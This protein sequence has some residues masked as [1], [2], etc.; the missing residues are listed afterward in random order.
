MFVAE[1]R[2]SLAHHGLKPGLPSSGRSATQKVLAKAGSARNHLFQ[3][4]RMFEW[5]SPSRHQGKNQDI[6]DWPVWFRTPN[7]SHS[8]KCNVMIEAKLEILLVEDE[9]DDVAL[10]L[11]EFKR[12]SFCNKVHVVRSGEEALDFIYAQGNYAHRK[13]EDSLKLV[14][15]DLKLP[16]MHGLDVLRRI[17]SDDHSK[18]LSVV[19]LTASQEER[20]VMQCYK[21]GA[22][23]CIVKPFDFHKFID[24]VAEL[25]F[26]WVLTPQS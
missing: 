4:R 16:L 17:K 10:T 24:A 23:S 14:L 25:H 6:P 11:R 3:G 19:I 26:C 22:H 18:Q 8:E 5:S 7:L 20:G 1:R 12:I 15:L 2:A 21:L 13:G 9:P